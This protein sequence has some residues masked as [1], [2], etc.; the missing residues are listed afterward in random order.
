LTTDLFYPIG[1][2]FPI[3]IVTVVVGYFFAILIFYTT[4][5]NRL[6]IYQPVFHSIF[7][8]Q[9]LLAFQFLSSL[10]W[11]YLAADQL[12]EALAT[13]GILWGIP[14]A[15]LAISVLSWGNATSDTVSNS[16]PIF[17]NI[18]SLFP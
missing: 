5:P 6:P 13:L 4:L 7:K 11:I 16:Y 10:V 1:G 14:D 15:F 18:Q 12:L 2:I 8:F 9:I 3:S 17:I